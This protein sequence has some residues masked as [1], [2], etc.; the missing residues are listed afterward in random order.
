V[1]EKPMR[2]PLSN[3][4]ILGFLVLFGA[5]SL[6]G[7]RTAIENKVKSNYEKQGA[8]AKATAKPIA[9]TTTL[10]AE[11]PAAFPHEIWDR[12]LKAYVNDTGKVDYTGLSKNQADLQLYVAYVNAYSP[13]KTPELFPT[14]Q[15]KEAYYLNAYNASVFMNVLDKFSTIQETKN[16]YKIV[17]PF[18]YESVFVYGGKR[19]NLYDLENK[20]IRP[21]FKDP[22]V[23]FA[24]NCASESCPRLPNEAFTGA[25]LDAQLDREAKEFCSDARNVKVDGTT[26]YLSEIFKFYTTDFVDYEKAN[27]GKTS[28]EAAALTSY[29]NRYREQKLPDNLTVK[30]IPYNWTPNDQKLNP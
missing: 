26:L 19:D 30:F 12:V 13:E 8:E 15:D 23:H 18:F 11:K 1:K 5:Y 27:G 9:S 25:Q 7:C 28:S 4:I 16:I 21:T 14:P 29:I 6:T 3:R 24:L 2:R 22:R 17:K 20:T 10:P